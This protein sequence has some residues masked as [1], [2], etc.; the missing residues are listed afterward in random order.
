[1]T[2]RDHHNRQTTRSAVVPHRRTALWW[3]KPPAAAERP[4]HAIGSP[5]GRWAYSTGQD[6]D[7]IPRGVYAY[8]S[9]PAEWLWLA[10][11]PYV[12][13][14]RKYPENPARFR[15]V[16]HLGQRPDI[17]PEDLR[18][19]AVCTRGQVRSGRWA[20]MLSLPLSGDPSVIRAAGRAVLAEAVRAGLL[21]G[22]DQ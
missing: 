1:M 21:R 19:V 5:R 14:V 22:E 4:A 6:G 9:E 13:A 10:A 20:Q 11:L 7:G 18:N 17:N 2:E 15:L 3:D 8:F 12:L 16:F